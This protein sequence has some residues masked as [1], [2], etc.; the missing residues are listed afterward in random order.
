MDPQETIHAKIPGTQ[1]LSPTSSNSTI[2]EPDKQ[3]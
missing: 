3:F 1:N 2:L